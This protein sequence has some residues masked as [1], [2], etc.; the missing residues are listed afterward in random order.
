LPAL[1]VI[2]IGAKLLVLAVFATIA[3]Y[4]PLLLPDDRRFALRLVGLR[5]FA[6]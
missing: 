2:G 5:R 4:S 1:T 3:W 6:T